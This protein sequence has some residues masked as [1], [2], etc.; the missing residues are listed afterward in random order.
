M[1]FAGSRDGQDGY[2]EIAGIDWVLEGWLQLDAADADREQWGI[3]LFEGLF[4][5]FAARAAGS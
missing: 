3:A 5:A 1:S 4:Q 2:P